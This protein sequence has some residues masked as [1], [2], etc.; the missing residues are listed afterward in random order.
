M[1]GLHTNVETML[2]SVTSVLDSLTN[3]RTQHLLLMKSSVRYLD[4]LATSIMSPQM[5][6]NKAT[7]QVKLM[8]GVHVSSHMLYYDRQRQWLLAERRL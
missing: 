8:A 2:A 5:L 1:E 3:S 7:A 6:A 4:R